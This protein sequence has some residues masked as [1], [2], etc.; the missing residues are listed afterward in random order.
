[1]HWLPTGGRLLPG[2][3]RFWLA[4]FFCALAVI[5]L[6]GCAGNDREVYSQQQ[7]QQLVDKGFLSPQ[8]RNLDMLPVMTVQLYLDTPRIFLQGDGKPLMFHIDGKVDADVFGGMV[9]EKLPV[10]ITGFT[11]LRY[12]RADE[13]IY[14]AQI[15]FMEARIDLEVA[16]FKTMIVDSFQKALLKELAEMPLISLVK[17]PE[18]AA[19]IESL[20]RHNV[21]GQ[22]QFDTREGS[23]VI[24]PVAGQSDRASG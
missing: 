1:M 3:I 2:P 21:D 17:T 8:I 16:L 9:T 6:G 14:F 5:F 24:E 4:N 18:L 7:F 10:Q 19:I 12:S 20:A 11:Q 22:I 23:L 15:A 13:A